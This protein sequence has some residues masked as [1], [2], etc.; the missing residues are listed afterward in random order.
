[1]RSTKSEAWEIENLKKQH[2][3]PT[4]EVWGGIREVHSDSKNYVQILQWIKFTHCAKNSEIQK[5]WVALMSVFCLNF[6]QILQWLKFTHRAKIRNFVAN[7]TLGCQTFSS[8]SFKSR[9]IEN[10]KER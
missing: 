9:E 4:L 5:F 10:L 8:K 2:N 1:V 6:V 3:H 7:P